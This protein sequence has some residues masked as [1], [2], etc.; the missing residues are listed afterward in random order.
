MSKLYRRVAALDGIK[1]MFI[2]SGIRYDLIFHRTKDETINNANQKYLEE[3]ILNH[4]SGRLKV[5]PEHTSDNVLKIM[6]KPPLALFAKLKKFFDSVNEKAG[7]K[8]N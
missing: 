7:L 3:V 8:Q 6:R 2:G 4:V 5:A 1:K